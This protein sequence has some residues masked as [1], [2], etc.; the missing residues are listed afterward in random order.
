MPDRVKT[1][2]RFQNSLQVVAH[3]HPGAEQIGGQRCVAQL[4][5]VRA[6]I[7]EAEGHV[8]V[9][10]QVGDLVWIVVGDVGAEPGREVLRHRHLAHDVE[11]GAAAL[12]REVPH[13][14][15]DELGEPVGL[16]DLEG[17]PPGSH[18]RVL[19]IGC[20]EG[21]PLRIAVGSDAHGPPP[22]QI[23]LRKWESH[24]G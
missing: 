6:G 11:R 5:D 22:A 20:R 18:R 12:T 4:V 3:A 14:A 1:R 13:P 2:R 19:E 17:V 16:R 15:A 23:A 9:R 7:G 10:E 21:P 8:V 24:P